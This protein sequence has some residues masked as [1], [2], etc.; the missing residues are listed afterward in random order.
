MLHRDKDRPVPIMND[1]A[2][3]LGLVRHGEEL[4]QMTPLVALERHPKQPVGLGNRTWSTIGRDPQS[5]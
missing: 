2:A 3:G 1:R 5:K 4:D